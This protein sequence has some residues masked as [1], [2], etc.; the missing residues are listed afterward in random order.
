[1]GAWW[2]SEGG[3]RVTICFGVAAGRISGAGCGRSSSPYDSNNTGGGGNDQCW[4]GRSSCIRHVPV[5]PER[6]SVAGPVALCRPAG[7]S[8]RSPV[9]PRVSGRSRRHDGGRSLGNE[10]RN[11]D[12]CICCGSGPAAVTCPGLFHYPERRS[13]R[14]A[15]RRRTWPNGNRHGPDPVR[16]GDP[17]HLRDSRICLGSGC[18]RSFTECRRR[19]LCQ[20]C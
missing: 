4:P 18:G 19:G 12:K 11:P 20:E 10:E 3:I 13:G 5:S 8:D 1:V 15:F 17:G 16:A 2:N 6:C 7:L 9:R 14:R